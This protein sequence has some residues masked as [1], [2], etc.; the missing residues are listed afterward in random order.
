MTFHIAEFGINYPFTVFILCVWAFLSDLC[1]CRT[2]LQPD[3]PHL[4]HLWSIDPI[5]SKTDYRCLCMTGGNPSD[6]RSD[7][8]LGTRKLCTCLL[9]EE[10]QMKE[11]KKEWVNSVVNEIRIFVIWI[12]CPLSFFLYFPLYP[13]TNTLWHASSEI[14]F[15]SKWILVSCFWTLQLSHVKL[16]HLNR[17]CVLSLPTSL[18]R[19]SVNG[20]HYSIWGTYRGS[21]KTQNHHVDAM[22]GCP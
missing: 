1:C 10:I 3:S 16:E 8:H 17:V 19:L 13:C 7:G 2:L 22:L 5:L 6:K 21:L 18:Y 12:S 14:K 20:N 9:V 11:R 15:C 4:T